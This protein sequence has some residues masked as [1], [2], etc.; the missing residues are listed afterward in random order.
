MLIPLSYVSQMI[1]VW[2]LIGTSSN[3]LVNSL[4]QDL[5]YPGFSMFQFLPL[6]VVCTV[7]G[8]IY[9]LTIGRWSSLFNLKDDMEL[10]FTSRSKPPRRRREKVGKSDDYNEKLDKRIMTE[11]MISP[12]SLVIGRK[13]EVLKRW[14]SRE[15]SIL[16]IQRRGQVLR[17]RLDQTE[18]Q[19]GDILLTVIGLV[20][21]PVNVIQYVVQTRHR[22]SEHPRVYRHYFRA[23]APMLF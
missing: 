2:T 16:C 17:D 20:P 23:N 13:L 9:L 19:M 15:V 10:D 4:A 18:L 3:L 8:S 11:A 5:A 6:G 14:I 12:N 22:K 7:V 1:G 21:N